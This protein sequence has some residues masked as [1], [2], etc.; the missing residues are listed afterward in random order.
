MALFW[1]TE[2]VK[3]LDRYLLGQ[4]L[5]NLL[6][7][8]G[9]LMAI[10]LLVDFF[11]RIDNFLERGLPVGLATR[12]FILKIPMIIEQVM[13]VC[14][15]LAGVLTLG[16]LNYRREMTALK[17]GGISTL[18]IIRPLAVGA[19]LITLLGTALSQ[20]LLP[21]SLSATNSIWYEEV[22]QRIPRGID[23]NGRI[24]Y[25]GVE[26][27]YSFTRPDPRRHHF[28]DF[29]YLSWN[30][31][32]DYSLELLLTAR[33][34]DWQ[35]GIWLFRNGQLKSRNDA[36]GYPVEHFAERVFDLPEQPADL[37]VPEYKRG[38]Y[39]LSRLFAQSRRAGFS[40]E[41]EYWLEFNR[42]L[43]YI[44]LGLPLFMIGLP[45]LLIVNQKWGRDLTFA[46]PLSTS[47]AFVAWGWWSTMQ[48]LAVSAYIGPLLASWSIHLLVG[49]A[50]AIMLV[51]LNR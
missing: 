13:P 9:S 41:N 22:Q 29:S 49:S 40:G 28:T 5:R 30:E 51:R 25:D 38:E 20:W 44:F 35:D 27:I 33:T 37:F 31:R 21:P 32:E 24:Y 48:S 36:G 16:L 14:I 18:R 6:L 42:R 7:V 50:G 39:S 23:R 43:S 2:Q 45:V 1:R 4:F 15:L 34:A 12:Y 26:G 47:L 17:A 10:Y 8:L 11:E 46:V 19:V 3:L